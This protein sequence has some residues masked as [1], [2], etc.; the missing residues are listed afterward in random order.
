AL[1]LRLRRGLLRGRLLRSRRLLRGCGLR[2]SRGL[3]SLLRTLRLRR[4]VRRET[5]ALRCRAVHVPEARHRVCVEALLQPVVLRALREL[6]DRVDQLRARAELVLH[7]GERALEAKE[8]RVRDV[9][10][11]LVRVRAGDP[12]VAVFGDLLELGD[13]LGLLTELIFDERERA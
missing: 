2:G 1:L 9:R 3:R 6:A 10:E 13:E 8:L 12:K 4:A 5:G 11:A 7:G